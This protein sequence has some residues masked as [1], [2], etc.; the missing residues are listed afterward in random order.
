MASTRIILCVCLAAAFLGF[1]GSAA[2]D[3]YPVILHGKVVMQDGSAPPVIM[4]IERVCSDVNGS[5]PGT[6]TDKKGEYIWRMEIDPLETRD[7][8]I[9]ATHAGYTSTQVEVSGVDTTH[10]T[11]ELPPIV[12]SASVADPYAIIIIEGGIPGRAKKDW[13]EALKALDAPDG[14][15]SAEAARHLEAAVAASPKFGPG[16][17]ALGVVDERLKKLPEARAAYE[18]AVESAPKLLPPYV[19]LLRACIKLKDWDGA[20]KAAAA[21]LKADPKHAYP[22]VYLH[23]AVAQ[24]GL[25]DYTA[26]EASVQEAIRLDPAHT[27][28]RA[29]YVLGRILE[30]KGETSG[31]KEHMAMYLKLDPAPRD[32]DLVKGHLDLMGKPGAADVEPELEPL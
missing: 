2:A 10:T 16:W 9:R 31:A 21:L 18:H 7:C 4:G 6:L 12:V 1:T 32:V 11:L 8:K 29:E 19:A 13:D 3:T 23:L 28:P 17:H 15:N 25:K 14:P 22:E 20:E 27:R 24:Y 5:R 30:A 26:A